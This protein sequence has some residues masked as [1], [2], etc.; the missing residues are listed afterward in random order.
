MVEPISV[1]APSESAAQ[2]LAGGQVRLRERDADGGA[3]PDVTALDGVRA[4]QGC[5]QPVRE[6][7]DVLLAGRV[8]DGAVASCD[9]DKF[10]RSI[11]SSLPAR[12]VDRDVPKLVAG[13]FD[14]RADRIRRVGFVTG[15]GIVQE[16][17]EQGIPPAATREEHEP[18]VSWL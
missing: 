17:Y 10:I 8:T 6:L 16:R 18:C 5:P 9:R 7:V 14:Q 4:G 11:E 13:L 12:V 15:I 2:Q 3:D 1:E